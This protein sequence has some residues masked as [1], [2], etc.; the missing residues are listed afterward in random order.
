M[1][2]L[3][4]AYLTMR[5]E[6]RIEW[7]LDSL[8]REC[9]GNYEGIK[10]VVV[11]SSDFPPIIHFGVKFMEK[12]AEQS[13]GTVLFTRVKPSVWQGPH[14]LT[15]DEWFDASNAR[16]TA[17]CYAP[18]GWIAYVDDLSVLMPGWLNA[19][20]MAMIGNYIALGAYKKVKKLCVENGEVK[21][22]EEF[23][24]GIDSRWSYGSDH[25]AV[26]ATG[27]MM[28]GCSVAMPVEA[29]LTIN[30]W[31]ED[32]CGG[33]GSEDYCCGLALE[34]AGYRFKYDRRMLT[35]ESEEDHHTGPVFRKEDWHFENGIAVPGGNG[36]SDKSHA[37]L[38]IAKQSKY[39]PNSFGEG[40]I[41]ALRDR[42]LAG[43]SF[44]VPSSPDRDWFTGKLLSEL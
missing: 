11:Y 32:L 38:N 29:L 43:E 13:N 16:S 40:G 22:F 36:G 31:P 8:H 39:F 27:G 15:K 10:V 3:T 23:P 7:F 33:L 44:P 17:L 18:D 28:Y 35:L 1:Q 34:N 6:P 42:I 4:V 14:R 9:G 2:K 24:G 25:E 20:K 12:V 5:K 30:G 37:A 19:V 41:R 26:F 21:S